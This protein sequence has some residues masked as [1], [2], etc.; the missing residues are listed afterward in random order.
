VRRIKPTE[1][2]FLEY[3][4]ISRRYDVPYERQQG[5]NDRDGLPALDAN[6]EVFPRDTAQVLEYWLDVTTGEASNFVAAAVDRGI[7]YF[8]VAPFYGNAQEQLYPS[9]LKT[10]LCGKSGIG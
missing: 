2:M 4:P 3:A 9:I 8:D 6:L 7:N 1:G 10:G 5:P